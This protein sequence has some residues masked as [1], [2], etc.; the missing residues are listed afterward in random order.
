MEVDGCRDRH[1]IARMKITPSI[2]HWVSYAAAKVGSQAEMARLLTKELCRDI[3]RS[4]VNKMCKGTR[5]V[6]ADELW[7]MGCLAGL[8]VPVYRCRHVTGEAHSTA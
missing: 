3:D 1:Y 7:A 4:A 2:A 8:E 5:A 6:A